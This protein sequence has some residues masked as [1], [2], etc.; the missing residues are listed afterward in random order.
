[1]N[2][3]NNGTTNANDAAFPGYLFS[4]F[5]AKRRGDDQGV[6]LLSILDN[7]CVSSNL[8][9]INESHDDI[10][11]YLSELHSCE[12]ELVVEILNGAAELSVDI[13]NAR[14][15]PLIYTVIPFSEADNK[16]VGTLADKCP[17]NRPIQWSLVRIG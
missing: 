17:D 11:E 2:N 1:M 7:E 10:S 9:K 16:I 14:W 4:Q 12:S 8:S 3:T 5:V 15:E 6:A 13:L